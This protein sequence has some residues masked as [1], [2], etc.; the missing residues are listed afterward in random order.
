MAWV[1]LSYGGLSKRWAVRWGVESA[2]GHGS[3][4]FFTLSASDVALAQ[5]PISELGAAAAPNLSVPPHS[6]EA[7]LSE[8]LK[9]LSPALV[10][11]LRQATIISNINT[12]E[13]VIADISVR[14]S[15]LGDALHELAYNFD[16]NTILRLIQ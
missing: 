6:R 10:S 7:A 1:Y 12:I 16:Y 8:K 13:Q 4:F 2:L 3:T 5:S 9:A 14:D 11:E 15:T